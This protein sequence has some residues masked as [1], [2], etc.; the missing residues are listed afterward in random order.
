[1]I[2]HFILI[3]LR[4]F[5]RNPLTST[6]NTSSL[7]IGLSCVMIIYLWV[8]DE[9]QVDNFHEKG[10]RIVQ[11]LQNSKTPNGIET[12]PYTQGPLASALAN[13]LPEV[14]YSTC[15]IPYEWFDGEDHILSDGGEKFFI[16]KTQFA[17]EDYFNIFS[18]ELI[19]GVPSEVLKREENI[20]ISDE[21]SLK[22]F[23]TKNSIGKTINWIHDEY[24][25]EYQVSG[26]F[27]KIS[28]K[29]SIQFDAVLSMDVFLN[30]NDDLKGW[31]NSD[32]F[33]YAALNPDVDI[34]QFN[35]KIGNF[36]QSKNNTLEATLFAQKYTDRHLYSTFE[37]GLPVGGRISYVHLFT[38][39]S[40][41]ILI[42]ACANFIN[43]STAKA[44]IRLKEIGVK[45]V[46]GA[47]RLNLFSQHLFESILT[48][49][50]AFI[51]ATVIIQ[52][53]L[54][55]F[56]S[57]TGKE[58]TWSF[59]SQST[60]TI[61]LITIIT[62][63]ISGLYP[64]LY[65]SSF[66]PANI[67]KR[68]IKKQFNVNLTRTGLVV[69]QFAI[70]TILLVSVLIIYQ[71]VNLIQN[72]NLGYNK[73]H[74]IQ[75]R[76]GI[77]NQ[78][79]E[80]GHE[81]SEDDIEDY[82]QKLKN[83][84]GV[85]NATNFAYFMDDFGNTD[86]LDWP[87]KTEGD[88]I[89]F[90]NVA[91]GYD[92]IETLEMNTLEGR[93][94]SREYSTEHEKIIFNKNAIQKMGINDPIGKTISLWGKEKEIIGVVDDF[95]YATLYEDIGPFF[96]NLTTD[97]FASNILVKME[98]GNE[99]ETIARI[100]DSYHE[101]F[102]AGLP[103]EYSFLDESY[104]KLYAQEIQ[105]SQLTKLGAAIAIFISCLGL[106]GFATFTVHRRL[107]EMAIRKILGSS[108]TQILK[109]MI[110]KFFK[111]ILLSFLIGFPISY[112]ISQ[113]WLNQFSYHIEITGWI[114]SIVALIISSVAICTIGIQML[115]AIKVSLVKHLA[116][117]E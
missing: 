20:V 109:I 15:V 31:D 102:I 100:K 9:I 79:H 74:I 11:I 84:P 110:A 72:K 69:L 104:D 40:I 86:G 16:S 34:N 105:A 114:F 14:E 10:D 28:K 111:P 33:T 46:M 35:D 73:E 53:A 36:L 51:I 18:F 113:N 22:L 81:L 61:L 56:N 116:T 30:E 41:F 57:I 19:H 95:H 1:M 101:Y 50:L 63:I 117:N 23:S 17:S 24:G 108:E 60:F 91:G 83:I 47:D 67:F 45:K 64:A 12:E 70:S 97:N 115:Q 43:M 68:K 27:K 75:F 3:A 82:L 39:I 89:Y 25:G 13:D 54:P 71:Q 76:L 62:G 26:I 80:D 59:I 42:I 78:S 58:I 21:L 107:K 77:Q 48:A 96:I 99:K 92:F 44:S 5:K 98:T 106:F 37:N 90:A 32:P 29:S 8:N 55:G 2:K 38:I 6:I 7:T 94:F 65:L 85:T 93:T 88:D 103:F 52:F 49:L 4:N 112:Y 87:G 66:A